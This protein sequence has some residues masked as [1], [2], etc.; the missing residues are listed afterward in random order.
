MP[1]IYAFAL[2]HKPIS[3]YFICIIS[4]R[5]GTLAGPPGVR[6]AAPM[7]HRPNIGGPAPLRRG[8]C[9]LLADMDQAV[10]VE[11]KLAN[12]R[13]LDVMGLD[14]R[15]RF[16]G[17]EIKSGPADF[18]SDGKWPEYLPFC[19]RFLFAVDPAFPVHLLPDGCGVMVADAWG[20][21][22]VRAA[23]PTPIQA[24]RRRA[25]TL[26]FG[27]VAA[28]RLNRAAPTDIAPP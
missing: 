24:A 20:A 5:I 23:P 10:L 6:Y 9:R 22:V 8:V 19:D 16:T 21:R 14:A 26:V 18:R 7:E 2:N 25:Q 17:V 13:R 27:R 1:W 15:G 28:R 12:G 11:F 3:H 4:A